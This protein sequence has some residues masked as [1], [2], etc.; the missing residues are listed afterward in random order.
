MNARKPCGKMEN[1]F[2]LV[3]LKQRAD[4]FT[5]YK[6]RLKPSAMPY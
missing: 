5:A 2:L 3:F 1:A 4:L 6:A